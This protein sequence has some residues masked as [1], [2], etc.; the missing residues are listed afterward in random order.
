[1]RWLP[2]WLGE[3]YS[4]LYLN[5]GWRGRSFRDFTVREAA[6]R[7]NISRD[8]LRVA[9]SKLL[10]AGWVDR[11]A[12]GAY[13]L[14]APEEIISALAAEGLFDFA[15]VPEPFL[16][17]IR[18]FCARSLRSLGRRL[19]SMVLFGSVARGD[20][21]RDSDIDIL[22]VVEDLP[23]NAF[24]RD[25]E[26]LPLVRGLPHPITLVCYRPEELAQTPL[27][28]LDVAVDGIILYDTGFIRGKIE[29]VRRRLEELGSKRVGD[30]SEL[31]W[32]LKPEVG[33]GEEIE[34]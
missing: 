26:I 21:D 34:I 15:A 28:F 8:F 18:R 25:A 20:W 1:M 5:Y 24:D 3:I 7:L 23:E 16:K 9:L 2:S 17:T 14:R 33:L 4:K 10:D 6:E 29:G 19:R 22:L 30:K 32:I 12:R 27:L 31:T 13:R 11:V